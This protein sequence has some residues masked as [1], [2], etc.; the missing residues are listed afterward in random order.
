MSLKYKLVI[1]F[2]L[3]SVIPAITI[4]YIYQNNASKILIEKN[5]QYSISMST[6]KTESMERIFG[7]I[8]NALLNIST[9]PKTLNYLESVNSGNYHEDEMYI[10]TSEVGEKLDTFLDLYQEIDSISIMPMKDEL[11]IFRG[12]FNSKYTNDYSNQSAYIKSVGDPARIIWTLQPDVQNNNF[13]LTISKGLV[14]GYNDKL[15][16]VLVISLKI[17]N[18]FTNL[19]MESPKDGE[20]VLVTDETGQI[21]FRNN[22]G[23]ANTELENKLFH[24]KQEANKGNFEIVLDKAPFLITYSTLNVNGWR[25]YYITP[26]INILQGINKIAGLTWI[27]SV[28]FAICAIIAAIYV[29]II[30]YNPIKKMI[31]AMNKIEDGNLDM[32]VNITSRDELG[33]LSQKFNYLIRQVR[34]LIHDV[35]EDQKRKS[36]LEIKALQAQIMPHFLYNTLNCVISLARLNKNAIIVE[37]VGALI[38]LLRVS[39]NNQINFITIHEE[40]E[41][42]KAYALIMS[43]RCDVPFQISYSIQ[44]GLGELGI[45]KFTIQPIVENSIIHAFDGTQEKCEIHISVVSNQD[46]ICIE[47][48]DNGIGMDQSR[49]EELNRKITDKSASKNKFNGIGIENVHNR[50]LAEYGPPAGIRIASGVGKGTS[51]KITYPK[52]IGTAES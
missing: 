34:A 40:V 21:I 7:D 23:K 25:I 46:Y 31:H 42:V 38:D 14:N 10:L 36:E 27:I 29:F 45:Q 24:S 33:K 44:E 12:E 9:N 37:M 6:N 26:K 19:H 20:F 11:P 5:T 4:I 16:G 22:P 32:E 15:L 18:L 43:Y 1:F 50:L 17:K 48:Q 2:L 52:I 39:A 49:L 30:L 41:Y 47:V 51:V 13:E 35:K 28:F 8:E 3:I